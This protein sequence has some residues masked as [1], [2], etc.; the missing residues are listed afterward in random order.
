MKAKTEN[1]L[2]INRIV[3]WLKHHAESLHDSIQRIVTS[4]LSFIFTVLMIA[5]AFSIPISSYIFFL[6]AKQLTQQWDHDKQ[7]TLF[8]KK[9]ISLSQANTLAKDINAKTEIESAIVLDKK[10]VLEDFKTQT[11]LASITDNLSSNPLPH[12]IVATPTDELSHLDELKALQE[13]LENYPQINQVQFDLI[14][15]QRLQAM[16]VIIKRIQWIV[17]LLLLTA[18]ALI[19][20]NVI[21]WEVSS[22]HAEIEI[23]KLVGATDAYVKRPFLYAGLWLGLVGA[24]AAIIIIA[25]S[26][27]LIQN[28]SQMLS[29]LFHNDLQLAT[30]PAGAVLLILISAS[31][32]GIVSAWIAVTHKLSA[33]N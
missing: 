7:I 5:I 32:I 16:L 8:L 1:K 17:T 11:G 20:S 33:Y 26:T 6:S 12:L 24:L 19:I 13:S 4:P 21:R 2:L 9:D 15:Y 14:W 30:L 22:R 27:W 31:V 18:I 3:S 23:I 10:T 28:S 25:C 29:A